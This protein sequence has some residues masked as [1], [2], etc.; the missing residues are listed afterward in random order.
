M[1]FNVQTI[2]DVEKRCK[3]IALKYKDKKIQFIFGVAVGGVVPGFLVAKYM[4]K[5]H[6]YRN[7]RPNLP[8][9]VHP[10]LNILVI[11]DIED[12]GKT[13]KIIKKSMPNCFYETIVKRKKDWI[14]FSWETQQDSVNS[15]QTKYEKRSKVH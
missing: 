5:E 2:K 10:K 12:T 7:L 8:F 14:I 13:K 11:D 4:R 6:L 1:K 3:Q 15:R 9:V